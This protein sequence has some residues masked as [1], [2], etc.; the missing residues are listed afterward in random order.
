[1]RLRRVHS[2]PPLARGPAPNRRA[3]VRKAVT[4]CAALAGV[5]VLT[6]TALAAAGGAAPRHGG[7][8]AATLSGHVVPALTANT[9]AGCNRSM[10]S[11]YVRCLAVVR[12]PASHQ[13]AAQDGPPASALGPAD[14]QSAYSLPAD[15]GAGQTV[16]IVDA[17]GDSHAESDL[18]VF[19]AQYGLPPCTTAN[20]CFKKVD[21]DG[22]TSYPA[23]DTSPHGWALETALDLDAVSSAC[24]AC[25]I[26]LVEGNTTSFDDLGAAVDEAV[27]LGAKYVSNSYAANGGE[28]D[29]EQAYDHYYDHPGVAV[30]ASS[31]DTGNVS[32]WPSTGQTVTS[33]G[34]TTLAKD[35]TQPRGWA[36]TAWSQGGSGCSPYEPKPDFQLGVTTD[37]ANRA[38]ADISADA[39]PSSGLATYDTL[40]DSGWLQVGGTSL[41]SPLVAAMYALAGTPVPGT[42]PVTYPYHDP[43]QSADLNDVTAGRNGLCG[44]LLCTAGPGWDGPTGLGTPDGVAALRSGPHGDITGTVTDSVT[45]K[46]IAGAT[47]TVSPGGYDARTGDDG[48]F[49]VNTAVGSYTVSVADYSYKAQTQSGVTVTENQAT[50]VN[51]A[52][53]QGPH[54]VVTGTV[55]DGSGHGWPLYAQITIDGYPGGPVYTDPF[56]GRYSVLLAGDA[57]YTVHVTAADPAVTLPLGAGYIE[58]DATLPVGDAGT[59]QDFTLAVDKTACVAPGYGPDGLAEGFADWPGGSPRDGWTV[60]GPGWRFDNPGNRPPPGTF[61]GD[62]AFAVADSGASGPM[63]TTLTSPPVSLAG[64]ASPQLTFTSGYYGDAGQAATVDLS[65]DNG[66]TWTTIWRQSAADAVGPQ[67]IAIP[68]AAGQSAVRVRFGYTASRGASWWAID[69]VLIG[70]RTCVPL[71]GGLVAGLVTTASGGQP[72]N[73]ATISGADEVSATGISAATG[74]PGMAGGFYVLFAPAGASQA[75]T[76]RAD[77]YTAQNAA[78]DVAADQI[79]RHDW[80]LAP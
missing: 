4:G 66:R 28:V 57:S 79:T 60:T 75:F 71:R 22:G 54:S 21:Q 77:G 68:R 7:P 16:A 36:E 63:R 53:V 62:D 19:R 48:S 65:T 14:I 13:I 1:M 73:A 2:K 32:S 31:G 20:G 17:L 5:A 39:N 61:G 12:T 29:G 41:S 40:D 43:A 8:A 52:L 26:L 80:A 38:S 15:G 74:D 10:P 18:A 9:D 45:G 42:Y 49:D 72:V 76:A 64:Q 59:S 24:P 11:G 58:T 46:P 23:D 50:T 35:T 67:D 78:I 51:F 6:A 55:R 70:A 34:G 3:V 56:T 25:N 69:R 37:C 47:V 27:T 33:V 30:T 44:N